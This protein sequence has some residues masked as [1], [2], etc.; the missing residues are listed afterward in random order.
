MFWIERTAMAFSGI[1]YV[2]GSHVSCWYLGICLFSLCNAVHII[3]LVAPEKAGRVVHEIT[4]TMSIVMNNTAGGSRRK[5]K[6]TLF[7]EI[8]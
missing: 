4:K 5:E 1:Y 7:L 6:L 2:Y 3:N 8:L